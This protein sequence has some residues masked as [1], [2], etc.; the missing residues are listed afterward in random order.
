MTVSDVMLA[1]LFIAALFDASIVCILNQT[2][3][4]SA[5]VFKTFEG[6]GSAPVPLLLSCHLFLNS[7]CGD[8]CMGAFHKFSCMHSQFK[9]RYSD[10][11]WI[12]GLQ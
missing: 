5:H 4:G 9:V 12:C 8:V 11:K 2:I 1:I 3:L 7:D 6:T 10:P